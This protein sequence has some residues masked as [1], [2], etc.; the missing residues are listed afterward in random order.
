MNPAENTTIR[1]GWIALDVVI[2]SDGKAVSAHVN[3]HP[4]KDLTAHAAMTI[5]EV[6]RAAEQDLV[7][8]VF[9]ERVE[10]ATATGAARRDGHSA[11]CAMDGE[12][13]A[14]PCQMPIS[15]SSSSDSGLGAH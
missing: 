4:G 10:G 8:R 14:C 1:L 15:G 13:S 6:A 7:R 11:I 12:A 9:P 5:A 2:G 3:V